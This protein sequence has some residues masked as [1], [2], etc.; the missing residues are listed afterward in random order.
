MN[1]VFLITTIAASLLGMAPVAQAE[2]LL[3]VYQQAKTYDAQLKSQE[4]NYLAILENKPQVLSAKK[5]QVTFN[6]N[7]NF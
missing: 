5:P 7:A 3:Q 6:A 4:S 2:T 1:R